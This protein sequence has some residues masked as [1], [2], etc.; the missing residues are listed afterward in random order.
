MKIAIVGSGISGLTAAHHLA[1]EH[2]V[3]LF[4]K[5]Q[6]PG[7]HSNTL[8]VV[9][10]GRELGIDTGFIVYNE[11]TYPSFTRLLAEL[12]VAT[13]PSE[14]SFS[15]SCRGCD[16]E[17]S[18]SGLRGLFAN[19]R[20]LLR[21]SHLRMLLE[22]LRFN[23][24]GAASL[25]DRGLEQQTLGEFLRGRAY[26]QSFIRHYVLAM[27]GAIWSADLATFEEF[28]VL[29]FLR[30]FHNHGLLTVSDHPEW[31]TVSGG[32]RRYV[33]AITQALG[34]RLRL[35]TPVRSIRRAPSHVELALEDGSRH[36]F[37]RVVVATHSNQALHLL[38]DPSE[39]ERRALGAIRYQPNEAVLHTDERLLP[40]RH[41]AWASWNVHLVDCG[42]RGAPL[43]MTYSL[44]HLQRL[45]TKR[46]YCVTLND[47]GRIAPER[48]LERIDYDHP[49][50]T[51]A[52]LE[53]QQAI[54]A[55]NGAR[56]TFYCGAYLGY[57][58][59]ED[60]VRS[61]LDV[62]RDIDERRAAA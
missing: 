30:F 62:V 41:A 4:E 58:F 50:Y 55:T 31:R 27:G 36:A 24:E 18:G 26:S 16:V 3:S 54:R 21:P 33:A 37:D 38:A 57:G 22:I 23:R 39:T 56:G 32:S 35:S 11:R 5:E 25:E 53:A 52:T 9:D 60:G 13:Q 28:P 8:S 42:R 12:G 34:E 14:M 49:V 43:T 46:R 59:H 61:A 2:D 40:R 17:Y 1:R 19:P 6:R 51:H 15:A 44:N 7:G 47:P 20:A 10:D 45:T 48:I 29:Y